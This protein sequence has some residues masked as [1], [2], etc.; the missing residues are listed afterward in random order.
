MVATFTLISCV[1]GN[2]V[3]SETSNYER[4]AGSLCHRLINSR[5]MEFIYAYGVGLRKCGTKY[6]RLRTTFHLLHLPILRRGS[7]TEATVTGP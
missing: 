2:P 6:S 5:Y 7:V 4:E 3:L 1:L